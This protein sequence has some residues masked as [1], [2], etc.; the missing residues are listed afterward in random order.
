MILST[1]ESVNQDGSSVDAAKSFCDPY[2]FNTAITRAKSLVV[3]VGNPFLLLKIEDF[4]VK[5]YYKEH[6]ARCWSTFFDMCMKKNSFY[7]AKALNLNKEDEAL[8]LDKIKVK[9]YDTEQHK[10]IQLE[11][12]IETLKE[13]IATLAKEKDD[14]QQENAALRKEKA[15]LKENSAIILEQDKIALEQQLQG[16]S[17]NKLG[18]SE[19]HINDMNVCFRTCYN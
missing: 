14:L 5:K 8:I 16:L 1:T 7:F 11:K 2:V 17:G 4:F 13:E 19:L 9:I 10:I 6:N 18:N 15:D 3:A 12:E